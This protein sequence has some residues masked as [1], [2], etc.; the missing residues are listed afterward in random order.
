MIPIVVTK[1]EWM[2]AEAIF[3]AAVDFQTV[4]APPD[5][6]ELAAAIRR[7]GARAAVVGVEKY[8]GPLYDALPQ[9]GVIA[10]FGVG[11][12]GIDKERAA[13]R[14]LFVANTPGVLDAAVAEHALALLLGAAKNL[15]RFIADLSGGPWRQERTDELAG[16]TLA[17][18]GC[19]A[20]GRRLARAAALGLDMR[21][22]GCDP[23]R[24]IY[25]ILAEKWNIP[26]CTPDFA[27]AVRGA[28]YVSLHIPASPEN[29]HFIGRERLE[30]LPQ[31][32]TLINTARGMIVDESALYDALA[33]GGLAAAALDVF[34]NEPYVPVS[35]EKDLRRL[36]N[37]LMTP[38]VASNT[39]SACRRMAERALENIRLILAGR[40]E[41]ADL[42]SSQP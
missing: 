37:V 21:V 16:K 36:P 20:I 18:I 39:E 8:A 17:V 35:P 13:K 32:C 23:R 2:K 5:E 27:E 6:D 4:P 10:R 11:H 24:E 26:H 40:P 38:H 29:R 33:S 19:G 25:P 9:G 41:Q 22:V 15:R 31:G 34:E 12:D 42:V 28:H 3:R 30:C 14:G 7:T 1:P